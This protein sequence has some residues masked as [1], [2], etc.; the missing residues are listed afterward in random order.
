MIQSMI[1]KRENRFFK[2]IMLEQRKKIMLEQRDE[3]MI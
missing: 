3:I 2:K 1:R